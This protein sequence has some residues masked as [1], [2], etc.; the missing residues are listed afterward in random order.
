MSRKQRTPKVQTPTLTL[1]ELERRA[2][3]GGIVDDVPALTA[4]ERN[5]LEE[6][7]RGESG[8]VPQRALHY[9]WGRVD[10]IHGI[11]GSHVL[12]RLRQA[13]DSGAGDGWSLEKFLEALAVD[14]IEIDRAVAEH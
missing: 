9:A 5:L 1:D 7:R 10:P 3:W 11:G 12:G 4:D 13:G 6:F 2:R 14:Q 8:W